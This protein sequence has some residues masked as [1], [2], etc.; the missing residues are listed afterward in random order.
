M[1]ISE[2]I[3]Y[4]RLFSYFSLTALVFI[5]SFVPMTYGLFVIIE[6]H[7]WMIYL[8]LPLVFVGLYLVSCLIFVV[9]HSKI[10]IPLT[11]PSLKPGSYELDSMEARLQG[12][13]LYADKIIQH[14]LRVLNFIPFV[15]QKYLIIFFCKFYGLKVGRNCYLSTTVHFDSALL[16]IGEDCFIGLDAVL[17]CHITESRR[18]YINRVIIGNNVTIGGKAIVTPGVVIEDG[19]IVGAHAFVPKNL[20]IKKDQIYVATTPRVLEKRR[21][22]QEIEEDSSSPLSKDQLEKFAL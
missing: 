2:I 7:D 6:N 16:E 21:V 18:L 11:L 17:S 1:N 12:V 14:L 8:F 22:Q 3:G 5:V 4:V 15:N 13:R 10:I 19:A 20:R 9:I